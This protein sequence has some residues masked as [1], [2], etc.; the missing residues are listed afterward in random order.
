[1]RRIVEDSRREHHTL[2]A[3][4]LAVVR[5]TPFQMRVQQPPGGTPEHRQASIPPTVPAPFHQ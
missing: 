4:V 3:L 1:V 5:S 2:P